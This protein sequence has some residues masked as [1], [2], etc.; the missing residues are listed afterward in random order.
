MKQDRKYLATYAGVGRAKELLDAVETANAKFVD[1]LT[2]GKKP[3]NERQAATDAR[4]VAT[5]CSRN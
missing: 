3:E 4:I 1:E 2:S 5:P